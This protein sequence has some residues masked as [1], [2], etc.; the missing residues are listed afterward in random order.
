VNVTVPVGVPEPRAVTV[1]L[2]ITACPVA[3]GFGDEVRVVVV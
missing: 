2:K 1:A 3:E